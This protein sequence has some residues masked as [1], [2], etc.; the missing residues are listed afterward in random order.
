MMHIKNNVFENIIAVQKQDYKTIIIFFYKQIF[1]F[2]KFLFLSI[3][4]K[5][6][7]IYHYSLI[8]YFII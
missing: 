1:F 6:N 5:K 2:S 3:F 7:I 4:S 8:I